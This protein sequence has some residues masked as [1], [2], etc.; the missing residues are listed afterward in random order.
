NALP[1]YPEITFS[2]ATLLERKKNRRLEKLNYYKHMLRYCYKRIADTD[3]DQGT[4]IIFSVVENIPECKEYNSRECLEFISN[5]LRGEDFDTTIL[6]NISMF[7]TW[8]Y[9]ELKK[10]ELK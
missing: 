10:E 1:I 9:L 8:K 3:E 4:D 5:K 7:I 6:T 2:A